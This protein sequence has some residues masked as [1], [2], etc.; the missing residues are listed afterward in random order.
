MRAEHIILAISLGLKKNETCLVVHDGLL[1]EITESIFNEA[2]N[3]STAELIEIPL[4][5]TNGEE[6]PAWCAEKMLEHDVI[7]LVTAKSMSHTNA[8]K[9]ATDNGARLVSMPG[10]TKD[11]LNRA[12]DVDY[13]GM[14][15]LTNK[16]ADILDSGSV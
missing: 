2:S 14:H 13:N 12:I 3:M 16:L 1:Y 11:T 15:R 7:V 6:P 4:L 5:K 9:N 8:R 10:I